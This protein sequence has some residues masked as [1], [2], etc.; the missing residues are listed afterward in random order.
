MRG[1][2]DPQ[3]VSRGRCSCGQCDLYEMK[4]GKFSTCGYCECSPLKHEVVGKMKL[5]FYSLYTF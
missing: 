4:E 2:L 5:K 1:N 3:N